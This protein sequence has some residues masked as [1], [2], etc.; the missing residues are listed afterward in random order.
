MSFK[1][2]VIG[3][4]AW[5]TAIAIF[6]ARL[7]NSSVIIWAQ[8]KEVVKEINQE[9]KNSYF[10]KNID[11]KKNIYATDKLSEAIA[12][13]IFYVTPAQNFRETITKQKKYIHESNEIIICSKGIE[14]SSGNLLSEIVDNILPDINYYILSGPSFAHEVANNKP[15]ALAIASKNIENSLRVST[16]ISNKNFRLYP[17]DDVIGVQLGGAIKNVYAISSGIVSGL[18]YGENAS[19]ALLTRAIS[20]MVRISISLGGKKESIFG[21]SGVGD[22]LLTCTSK[23]SRNYSLGV[24]IGK[25]DKI[26]QIISSKNTIAEGYFTTK[27]IYNLV[28]NSDVD[29]PIL[30][31]VYNILYNN[32]S[33]INEANRL[34]KRPIKNREFY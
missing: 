22:I 27:A 30:N 26:E 9:N 12:P 3:G 10:L 32:A 5:G 25:G 4:G 21:L 28:Q 15:A 17:S 13:Y 19:A 8:E 7:E 14:I 2:A 16:Y 18:N 31:S 23:L 11:L 1:F 34:L 33:P 20:E 29:T 24:S 6:L